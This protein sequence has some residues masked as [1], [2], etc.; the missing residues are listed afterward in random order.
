MSDKMGWKFLY[1]IDI[2]TNLKL[3]S[4]VDFKL[5]DNMNIYS[6]WITLGL[7]CINILN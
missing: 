6:Y 1:T 2:C 3:S 7:D 5:F 4:Y